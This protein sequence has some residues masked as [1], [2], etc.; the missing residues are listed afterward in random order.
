[1]IDLYPSGTNR[2]LVKH[3]SFFRRPL[4][5]HPL[6]WCESLPSTKVLWCA[7]SDCCLLDRVQERFGKLQK[8]CELSCARSTLTNFGPRPSSLGARI[9]A[10]ARLRDDAQL[11]LLGRWSSSQHL[12]VGF[13]ARSVTRA[14][15]LP[16][17]RQMSWSDDKRRPVSIGPALI[18]QSDS[19]KNRR[20][21]RP[22]VQKNLCEC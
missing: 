6:F 13:H 17:V 20:R 21:R 2:P 22:E 18:Q 14:Q 8:F 10:A 15:A 11:A 12:I 7:I 9:P 19:S 3:P 16:T 5:G 4:K 1:M